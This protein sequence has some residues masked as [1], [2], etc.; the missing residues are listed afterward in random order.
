MLTDPIFDL[1]KWESMLTSPITDPSH[2]ALEARFSKNTH[3]E[4][5]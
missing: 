5:E 2:L 3:K 4:S 1:N